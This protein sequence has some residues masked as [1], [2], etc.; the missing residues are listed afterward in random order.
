MRMRRDGQRRAARGQAAADTRDAAISTATVGDGGE[1]QERAHST[2]VT[3]LISR[4][5]VVPC[6]TRSTADSRRNSMP[7]SSRRLLD[8]RGRPAL[9]DHLADVIGQVE[10]LADRHAALEAGAAALDAAGAL[11]ER[12]RVGRAP[13]R[14]PTPRAA[15]AVTFAGRLQCA[16]M[17]RTSRC[18]STQFSAE[19][20]W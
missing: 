2:N 8:L 14:A 18:A 6:S 12:V 7:S 15:R 19:T 1:R 4:S 9:E 20:N 11:V 10:Q 16:Q 5:V 13:D 3:L 17:M